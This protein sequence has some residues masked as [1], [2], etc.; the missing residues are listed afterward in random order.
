MTNNPEPSTNNDIL[1]SEK[2]PWTSPTIEL[3]GKNT[4]EHGHTSYPIEG[5]RLIGAYSS[6]PIE[7]DGV[8]S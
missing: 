3:I 8:G 4:I 6:I 1:R 2:K 5:Y 7:G